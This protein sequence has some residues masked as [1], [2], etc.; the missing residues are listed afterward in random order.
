L[1]NTKTKYE[2]A[3]KR[4]EKFGDRLQALS[5]TEPHPVIEELNKLPL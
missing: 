3:D 4:L 1:T 5:S 2:E